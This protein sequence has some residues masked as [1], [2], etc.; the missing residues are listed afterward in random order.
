MGCYNVVFLLLLWV[1]ARLCFFGFRVVCSGLD[2][3]GF[4]GTVLDVE[5]RL[6]VFSVVC[7]FGF[8]GFWWIVAVI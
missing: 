4:F 1:S 5:L 8:A 2:L 3:A 7:G 6:H